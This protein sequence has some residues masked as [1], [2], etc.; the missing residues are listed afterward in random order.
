MQYRYGDVTFKPYVERLCTPSGVN[1]LLDSPPDHVHH[2]GLMF[3]VAVDGVNY[4]EET[5]AAGRQVHARFRAV[6][7]QA[8]GQ[9]PGTGFAEVLHWTKPS[10]EKTL[11]EQRTIHVHQTAE[12]KA[13]MLQWDCRLSKSFARSRG[14]LSGSHYFGLGM[15]FIRS[16]DAAGPFRNADGKPGTIFRGQERLVRSNWC[17]YSARADGKDVT[18]AMFGHPD[19]PRVATTWF[20]MAEPFAYLAAT[21]GLHEEPL[22][23]TGVGGLHLRYAVALFDGQVESEDIGR[24]YEQWLQALSN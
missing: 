7:V 1:V 5:P 20:T 13:T 17:A 15:R 21:L 10:G 4:W 11:L 16:M 22:R 12:P 9:L 19:N 3:A 23:I 18:I 2:H 6:N 8:A 14:V 24:L